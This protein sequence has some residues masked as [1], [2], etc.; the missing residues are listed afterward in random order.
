MHQL[1]GKVL[2]SLIDHYKK[3]MKKFEKQILLHGVFDL[4]VNCNNDLTL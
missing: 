2:W 4:I 1:I 3:E